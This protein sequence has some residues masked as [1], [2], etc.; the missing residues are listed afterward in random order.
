MSDDVMEQ[1]IQDINSSR[2][3]M[4]EIHLD[5]STEVNS[6]AWLL[7]FVWYVFQSD[8]KDEHLFCTELETTTTVLDVIGKLTSFFSTNGIAWENCCGVCADGAPAM[9]G[10]RSGLQK[11]VKDGAS[12]ERFNI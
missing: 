3:G 6:C 10:S 9:W 7:V 12:H 5:E 11:R 8:I 2:T 4:F 1:V